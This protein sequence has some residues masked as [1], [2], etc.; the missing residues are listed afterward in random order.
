MVGWSMVRLHDG[1]CFTLKFERLHS[2]MF[3]KSKIIYVM[4]TIRNMD[5]TECDLICISTVQAI[6]FNATYSCPN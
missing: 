1:I 2:F 6:L 5:H 3:L 4:G